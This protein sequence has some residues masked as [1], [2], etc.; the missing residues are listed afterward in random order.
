MEVPAPPSFALAEY[1]NLINGINELMFENGL[2]LIPHPTLAR[3]PLC[4]T[5]TKDMTAFPDATSDWADVRGKVSDPDGQP[6]RAGD[7][8]GYLLRQHDKQGDGSTAATIDYV[9]FDTAAFCYGVSTDSMLLQFD[10]DGNL[11]R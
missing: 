3:H 4:A 11:L 1:S 7:K 2:N 10:E 6:Y 8:P 9:G 5:G